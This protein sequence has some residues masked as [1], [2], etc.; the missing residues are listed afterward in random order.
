[1]PTVSN[2]NFSAGQVVA[3]SVVAKASTG[4][5][6]CIFTTSATQLVVDR[7][8]VFDQGGPWAVGVTSN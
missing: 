4:G 1:M 2:L 6:V 7:N 8:G 5:K 3:N